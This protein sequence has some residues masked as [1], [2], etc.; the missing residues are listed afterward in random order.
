MVVLT[1]KAKKYTFRIFIVSASLHVLFIGLVL[2]LTGKASQRNNEQVPSDIESSMISYIYTAPI[3]K[4][5]SSESDTTLLNQDE[6][7]SQNKVTSLLIEPEVAKPTAKTDAS[8]VGVKNTSLE[9]VNSV[10][11]DAVENNL[12]SIRKTKAVPFN[13]AHN[14][15]TKAEQLVNKHLKGLKAVYTQEQAAVY[16]SLQT[17]PIIDTLNAIDTRSPII[18]RAQIQVDCG[19][20]TK[21]ILASISFLGGGTVTCRSSSQFQ[22]YIDQ[23]LTVGSQIDTTHQLESKDD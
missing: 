6:T 10:V 21:Q 2:F 20:K 5:L 13:G 19:N 16:R 18:E 17:S 7:K 23:R 12:T 22:H 4:M 8:E 1:S 3:N 15:K 9:D 11:E 14:H